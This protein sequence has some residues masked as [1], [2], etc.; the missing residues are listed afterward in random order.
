MDSIVRFLNS[1]PDVWSASSEW[2][3]EEN[4]MFRHDGSNMRTRV[5][6]PEEGVHATTVA[7]TVI[8]SFILKTRVL[9]V[10]IS[11]ARET[12]VDAPPLS[13]TTDHVRMKQVKH[14]VV[15]RSPFRIDC[16]TV[17]CG[18]TRSETE[19]RQS[20]QNGIYEVECEF[21]VHRSDERWKQG[22]QSDSRLVMSLVYKLADLMMSPGVHFE[23]LA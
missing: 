20:S 4:Y 13:C 8:E 2:E 23:V 1:C 7:K 14:W 16:S 11:L 21:D 3:E 12:P 18:K 10:R 15:G 9:D 19:E 22:Y 17:W 5:R 6:F